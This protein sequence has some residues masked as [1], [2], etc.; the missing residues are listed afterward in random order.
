MLTTKDVLYNISEI[1]KLYLK[2]RTTR[3]CSMY[4]KLAVLEACGWIEECNDK[5]FRDF[6]TT[7]LTEKINLDFYEEQ[8]K[9]TNG[10]KYESYFRARLVQPLI[11]VVLTEKIEKKIHA[12]SVKL[13]IHK[14]M[15]F[16]IEQLNP[17]RN[18]SAHT[19]TTSSTMSIIAP[20]LTIS[21]LNDIKIGLV[22][23]KKEI[24]KIKFR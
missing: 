15:L 11:G 16:A 14:K 8:I 17:L 5:I 4:A 10:F 2:A 3:K 7:Y 21:Y 13:A 19:H 12:D 24:K 1:N 23:F 20:S 9:K 6:K 22:Q 18:D